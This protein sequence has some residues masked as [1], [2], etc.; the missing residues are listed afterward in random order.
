LHVWLLLEVVASI[1]VI[2]IVPQN[3]ANFWHGIVFIW[4][5]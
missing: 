2:V 4:L 3:D 5:F 1:S